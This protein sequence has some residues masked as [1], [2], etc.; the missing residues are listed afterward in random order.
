MGKSFVWAGRTI[1]VFPLGT[2]IARRKGRTFSVEVGSCRLTLLF[3][4]WATMT[5]E[6]WESSFLTKINYTHFVFGISLEERMGRFFF[7]GGR[8]GVGEFGKSTT[9]FQTFHLGNSWRGVPGID[10]E[11]SK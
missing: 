8:E 6:K 2:S 7:W 11:P 4:F 3:W 1:G 10:L 9:V 5:I